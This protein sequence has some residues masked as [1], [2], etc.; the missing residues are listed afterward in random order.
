MCDEQRQ[1]AF[2]FLMEAPNKAGC[3]D[4]YIVTCSLAYFPQGKILEVK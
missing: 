2:C 3:D 4:F 1:T